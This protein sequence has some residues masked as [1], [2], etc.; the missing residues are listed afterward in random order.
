[1][2]ITSTDTDQDVQIGYYLPSVDR[3]AI[4]Q[5]HPQ[6][7]LPLQEVFKTEEIVP[8]LT[9]TDDLLGPEE[10]Q[11]HLQTHL[12]KDPY[13]RH[14]VTKRILILQMREEPVWNATLVTSTLHFINLVLSARTGALLSE[15]IQSIMRLG[16]RA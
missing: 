16:K 7:L 12:E 6:R 14:P 10:I 3:L 1:V 11:L 8:K 5:L 9:L 15:D 4:F 13:R 2:F